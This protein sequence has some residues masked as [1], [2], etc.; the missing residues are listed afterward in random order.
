MLFFAT[1]RP[2]TPTTRPFVRSGCA[3]TSENTVCSEPRTFSSASRNCPAAP[4]PSSNCFWNFSIAGMTFVPSTS[5]RPPCRERMKFCSFACGVEFTAA[6][7]LSVAPAICP[8]PLAAVSGCS[9]NSALPR[10]S[11]CVPNSDVAICACCAGSF[12]ARRRVRISPRPCLAAGPP[13]AIFDVICSALRPRS[14][15]AATV[16][17][18]PS[19][20][21]IENSLTASATRSASRAPPCKP[22]LIRPVASAPDKPT[23]RNWVPYSFSVSSRSSLLFAPDWKPFVMMSNASSALFA[24]PVRIICDTARVTPPRS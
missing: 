22:W 23:L 20:A 17:F 2:P 9:E 1:R 13:L 12:T 11:A 10:S 3:C 18:D 19:T 15:Y 6:F 7:A 5:T 16:V 24:M 4:S 8:I 14:L 21:R